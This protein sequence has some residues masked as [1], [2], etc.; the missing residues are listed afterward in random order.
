MFVQLRGLLG[1]RDAALL[2]T[3]RALGADQGGRYVLV[4]N[5]KNVV[6][7]RPVKVGALHDR[8]RVIEEGL[9]PSD[10]VVVNGVLRARPGATVN[11]K[12]QKKGS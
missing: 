2:V 5:E 1:K 4:V 9:R 12:R 10:W 8:M 6:E 7:Y 3:E 11:P